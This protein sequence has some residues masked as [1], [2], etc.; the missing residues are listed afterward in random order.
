MNETKNMTCRKRQ[1]LNG[2]ALKI[3][4]MFTMLLDHIGAA[5]LYSLPGC[6]SESQITLWPGCPVTLYEFYRILRNV[7]RIAF[8]IYCFL[9]VE[10]FFHTKSKKKYAFRLFLFALISEIP[11][12]LAFQNSFFS[13]QLQNVFWTLLFGLLCMTALE[14]QKQA[15]LSKALAYNIQI[16]NSLFIILFFVGLATILKTDYYGIGIVLIVIFYYYHNNRKTACIIG[17]LCFLWEPFS[18]PAFLCLPLYNGKR[19]LSLKY[20]FYVFYPLHLL[21]L[22][23]LHLYWIQ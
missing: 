1:P 13:L 23:F 3:I 12:D 19:G 14:K 6:T 4:A 7:G 15:A 20:L 18:L 5:F 22:Y 17:Y 11:F 21:L 16:S 2:S 8:P 10:G 9:L